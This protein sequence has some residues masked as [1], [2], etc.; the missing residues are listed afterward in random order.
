[1]PCLR[2]I[3]LY[4]IMYREQAPRRKQNPGDR[5]LAKMAA[6]HQTCRQRVRLSYHI[7][8]YRV[9]PGD[10][11]AAALAVPCMIVRSGQRRRRVR[12]TETT[13]I[14]FHV[15]IHAEE[16]RGRRDGVVVEL[17][18]TTGITNEFCIHHCFVFGPAQKKTNTP[19]RR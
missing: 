19:E 5:S 3:L 12:T 16:R 1:M 8:P 2:I 18:V 6:S 7:L 9:P 14:H 13:V 11:F 15:I 17:P 10:P 4:Y